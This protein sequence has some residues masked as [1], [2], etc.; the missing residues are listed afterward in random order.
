MGGFLAQ[1]AARL[2]ESRAGGR[3]WEAG[4][5]IAM[6]LMCQILDEILTPGSLVTRSQRLSNMLVGYLRGPLMVL[7]CSGPPRCFCLVLGPELSSEPMQ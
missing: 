3:E 6:P 1:A 2:S 4:Y 7:V 5:V